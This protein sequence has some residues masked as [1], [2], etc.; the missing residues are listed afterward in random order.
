MSQGP[1]TRRQSVCTVMKERGS[2]ESGKGHNKTREGCFWQKL[3][4]KSR[5][6]PSRSVRGRRQ[7]DKIVLNLVE[8]LFHR[9]RLFFKGCLGHYVDLSCP[10]LL[11]LLPQ[12][13]D[14]RSSLTHSNSPTRAYPFPQRVWTTRVAQ[15]GASVGLSPSRRGLPGQRPCAV[16]AGAASSLAQRGGRRP[17]LAHERWPK[18]YLAALQSQTSAPALRRQGCSI[19]RGP[20]APRHHRPRLRHEAH[21]RGE[22]SAVVQS[23]TGLHT[24]SGRKSTPICAAARGPVSAAAETTAPY[25][26]VPAPRWAAR[27]C[28]RP[29]S[30]RQR[31]QRTLRLASPPCPPRG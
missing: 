10:Y 30:A 14:C 2:L 28:S 25:W 24:G 22:A 1:V 13:A 6:V 21:R 8:C 31:A 12:Q 3:E 19:P 20:R 9:K 4:I 23:T 7:D 27:R 16:L 15:A 26:A 29:P 17:W 18:E 11:H 5:V